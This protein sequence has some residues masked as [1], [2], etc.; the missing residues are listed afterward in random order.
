[1]TAPPVSVIIPYYENPAGL[2]A[3]LAGISAQDYTGD[4][5]IIVADDGSATAPEVPAGV[6][7]VALRAEHPDAQRAQAMLDAV[8]VEL[9]VRRGERPALV[10]LLE[11]P[12]GPVELR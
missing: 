2:T 3:V 7:L 10:A 6:R 11:T 5:E 12:R 4:I 8:G 1:M 9:E